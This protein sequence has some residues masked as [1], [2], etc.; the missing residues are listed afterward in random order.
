MSRLLWTQFIKYRLCSCRDN[1][2]SSP[3]LHLTTACCSW[4]F[5]AETRRLCSRGSCRACQEAASHYF[6]SPL[7]LFLRLL[8]CLPRG[9]RSQLRKSALFLFSSQ[10]HLAPVVQ[11]L[12]LASLNCYLVPH[13]PVGIGRP[14]GTVLA[15]LCGASPCSCELA[16]ATRCHFIK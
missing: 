15:L 16:L 1:S 3:S 13:L 12:A 2:F 14:C 8:T 9:S 11:L 6:A 7:V 10:L 4:M 5:H